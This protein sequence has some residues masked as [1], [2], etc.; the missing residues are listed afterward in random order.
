MTF[1][2]CTTSSN[3]FPGTVKRWRFPS[4]SQAIRRIITFCICALNAIG[5]SSASLYATVRHGN[6]MLHTGAVQDEFHRISAKISTWNILDIV[7]FRV[8]C[9]ILSAGDSTSWGVKIGAFTV[10]DRSLHCRKSDESF[11][12]THCYRP[13]LDGH[14]LIT[15]Q[16][17]FV[18]P[19]FDNRTG[20]IWMANFR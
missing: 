18:W 7:S 8:N 20:L 15:E 9:Q 1:C 12:E 10:N 16:P 3:R 4:N 11:L 5:C 19:P 2:I 17:L 14:L 13:Y 6:R